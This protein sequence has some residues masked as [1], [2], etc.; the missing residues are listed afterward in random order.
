MFILRWIFRS[1]FAAVATKML[2][3]LLPIVGRALRSKTR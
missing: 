3:R 1:I 2:T